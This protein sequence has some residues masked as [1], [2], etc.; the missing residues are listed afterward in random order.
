MKE[1]E[2]VIEK[3]KETVSIWPLLHNG[4][5]LFF[6]I[7]IG[8]ASG[9]GNIGHTYIP[10]LLMDSGLPVH[11]ASTV[12]AISVVVEAP[13]IFFSDR[14]MDHWPL[15]VL[16]ALPIGIIFAQY[17][18]Y[19]LPSSVFLKVLLTL[20]AKHTTGMVLVMVSL[21]FIAQQVK[22]KDLVLAMAIVQGA[23]YL[24]TILL[25]PL[26][27]HFIEYGGYQLMSLFLAGVVGI[28]FVMTFALKMPQ[29]R[30]HSLFGGNVE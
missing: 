23:R 3:E 29:G 8:L 20:L 17:A 1:K 11:I 2:T 9:V 21:R 15:R 6:I 22:G 14:F 30:S 16:I 4:P 10:E 25:Q 26:A 12:V 19:A 7:L 28:V 13:L 24:G 5:Y 18:V 27:A